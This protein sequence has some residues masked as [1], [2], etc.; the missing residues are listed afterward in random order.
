M[1]LLG[2]PSANSLLNVVLREKHGLSYNIEASYTPYTDCGIVAVY[3]SCDH[4]NTEQC[5][6]LVERELHRL[7][8]VPLTPRR[9]AM[10]KRQ[11]IAQLA[12]SMESNEGYMLGTGKSFLL[13]DRVDTMEEVYA[14]IGALTAS[15]L[16][17]AAEEV[18][19]RTS[20]LIY[21]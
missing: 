3:F 18:F 12:I 5:L 9:L 21:K 4:A 7:C 10:A 1:N 14:K 15:D 17:A 16:T 6:D 20:R 19:G 2:G 13:H 8:T 11:F